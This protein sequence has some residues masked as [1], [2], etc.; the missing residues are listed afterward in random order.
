MMDRLTIP[1]LLGLAVCCLALQVAG[2]SIGLAV[3][4]MVMDDYR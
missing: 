2:W 4:L 3:L 1:D